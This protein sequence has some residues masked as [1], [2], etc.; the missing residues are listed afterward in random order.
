M[1]QQQQETLTQLEQFI[2]NFPFDKKYIDWFSLNYSDQISVEFYFRNYNLFGDNYVIS[3]NPNFTIE[4]FIKMNNGRGCE[5]PFDVSSNILSSD[6]FWFEFSYNKNVNLNIILGNRHLPWSY[7]GF[8]YNSNLVDFIHGKDYSF[9]H[10]IT[11]ESTLPFLVDF[12]PEFL[13]EDF[14]ADFADKTTD[15]IRTGLGLE[16]NFHLGK[17]ENEKLCVEPYGEGITSDSI[18]NPLFSK[19]KVKDPTE[20]G[21]LNWYVSYLGSDFVNWYTCRQEL[22]NSIDS[23]SMKYIP[24]FFFHSDKMYRKTYL[25]IEQ[26][27]LHTDLLFDLES[28]FY[29]PPMPN[30]SLIY[31]CG[32]PKYHEALESF[33]KI[34]LY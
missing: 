26:N 15:E 10:F 17:L 13:A 1:Q 20:I 11:D 30:S 16:T 19:R 3:M 6:N 8:L 2:L 34:K 4:H 7:L 23:I 27:Q 33:E 14:Y 18:L 9:Y 28:V 12:D 25:N 24:I 21:I 32:G 5:L 22:G 29:A 31:R